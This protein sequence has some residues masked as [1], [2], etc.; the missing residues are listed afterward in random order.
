MRV[1][2]ASGDGFIEVSRKSATELN[3]RYQGSRPSSHA[4]LK[5]VST[6]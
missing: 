2:F 1:P 5:L 4:T 3:W 6:N